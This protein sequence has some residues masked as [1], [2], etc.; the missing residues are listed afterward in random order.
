[1][2]IL[3]VEDNGKLAELLQR[4]LV[5]AGYIVDLAINIAL[6]KQALLTN[7]YDVV[8]LDRMLPDGDGLDLIRFDSQVYRKNRFLVLSAL[9]EIGEKVAGLNLGAD[10]YIAKP[11]EPDELLARIRVALRHP[12]TA[13]KNEIH[14]GNLTF[15]CDSRSFYYH[16]KPLVLP[17]RELA[18]LESLIKR[19]ERVALREAIESEMYG[20]DEEIISNTLESHISKL[21]K[22]LKEK[23]I[24][25]SICTIRGVGYMLKEI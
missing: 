7:N 8:I 21:R 15:D 11:F 22:N 14:C 17:R 24:S 18:V 10:D 1:M 13:I 6:G 9:H 23:Q 4:L 3:L 12:L 5:K 2:K 25:V 20:Y 16:G 19:S